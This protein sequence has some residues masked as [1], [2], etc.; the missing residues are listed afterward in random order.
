[1]KTTQQKVFVAHETP[2]GRFQHNDMEFSAKDFKKYKGLR[3][4]SWTV[5]YNHDSQ[6]TGITDEKIIEFRD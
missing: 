3:G 5:F 1:M 2:E 4:G 6:N